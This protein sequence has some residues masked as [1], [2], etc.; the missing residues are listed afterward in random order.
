MLNDFRWHRRFTHL[1]TEAFEKIQPNSSCYLLIVTRGHSGDMRVLAWAVG[2][3]ARGFTPRYIG[4][5]GSKRKVIAVYKALEKEGFSAGAIRARA[6]TG[7]IGYRGADS[8]RDCG[9]HYGGTDCGAAQCDGT[10][11]QIHQDF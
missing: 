2:T 1:T 6:C 7:G 4:M 8:R 5:M 9:E 11:E 10:A 3:E